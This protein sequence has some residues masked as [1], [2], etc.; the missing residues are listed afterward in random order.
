M[1]PEVEL[2]CAFV[3]K[4]ES[5]K[6]IASLTINHFSSSENAD[7]FDAI[8]RLHGADMRINVR[9]IHQ[10]MSE[11]RHVDYMALQNQ[12]MQYVSDSDAAYDHLQ[13]N[14]KKREIMGIVKQLQDNMNG[15]GQ[16]LSKAVSQALEEL[17][18]ANVASHDWRAITAAEAGHEYFADLKDR[19]DRDGIMG[20]PSGINKIDNFVGGWLA[21]DLTLIGAC[22]S[23][24][25]SAYGVFTA[26]QAAMKGYSVLYFSTEMGVKQLAARMIAQ[27]SGVGMNV[28]QWRQST[29]QKASNGEDN[30]SRIFGGV[31][32]LRDL[33]LFFDDKAMVSV[34]EVV[35]RATAHCY[36]QKCDLIIID[37]MHDITHNWEDTRKSLAHIAKSLKNAA[38]ML[39]VPII[40]LA[41]LN[42]T[43]AAGADNIPTMHQIEG[44]GAI[45]QACD[46][47]LILHHPY[48]YD[49][50]RSRLDY[51]IVIEKNRQGERGVVLN[52]A[53]EA[54]TQ[55]FF[56]DVEAAAR[57]GFSDGAF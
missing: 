11:T 42:R 55:Q 31:T 13:L 5:R 41:Q 21:P 16:T 1:S 44:A 22:S 48:Y 2:L 47:I 38:K 8:Q 30:L 39:N 51:K 52:C 17:S 32:K 23:M 33:P 35:K 24:G 29:E 49:Q 3:Q 43:A 27:L 14:G 18:R 4:P 34:E 12:L 40:T 46:N 10:T 36:S 45:A 57:A 37:H 54:R 53:F 9:S 26:L 50:S 15:N 28:A 19:I 20:I 6:H 7:I 25:K 56:S